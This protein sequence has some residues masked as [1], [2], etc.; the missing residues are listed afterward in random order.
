MVARAR[1]HDVVRYSWVLD[2]AFAFDRFAEHQ[3]IQSTALAD[4][5]AA[6]KHL[7]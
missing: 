5:F 2:L 6:K 1:T 4:G 7:P 3:W